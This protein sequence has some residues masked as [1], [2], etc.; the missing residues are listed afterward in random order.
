MKK[1]YLLKDFDVLLK[2]RFTN[3]AELS[4]RVG[5]H[6][7]TLKKLVKG[8]TDKP[9]RNTLDRIASALGL[10]YARDEQG[11]YFYEPATYTEN[12]HLT[13]RADVS[14][15]DEKYEALP[16]E[17]KKLIDDFIEFYS[18]QPERKKKIIDKWLKLMKEDLNG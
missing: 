9:Q 1:Y 15:K 12:L 14:V 4:R 10:S 13:A 5:L 16:P 7:N 3:R 8:K 18:S 11:I 6:E 2:E 17:E